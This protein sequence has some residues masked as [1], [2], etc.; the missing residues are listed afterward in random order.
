MR[1]FIDRL[2]PASW[3]R[4]MRKILTFFKTQNPRREGQGHAGGWLEA[5][6]FTRRHAK[7]PLD[8]SAVTSFVQA[9][10]LSILRALCTTLALGA[11]V[12]VALSAPTN[13]IAGCMALLGVGSANC[14]AAPSGG[15]YV[16]PANV[17]G[18][19]SPYGCWS[20][21]ACT[22]AYA[23]AG[24]NIVDLVDQS[25]NNAIT[26]TA[27]ANGNI[28]LAAINAWVT[29]NSVTGI[30]VT[31]WYDQSGNGQHLVTPTAF[32][33]KPQ[34]LLSGASFG[35]IPVISFPATGADAFLVSAS[36]AVALAQ[37]LTTSS[38]MFYPTFSSTG[39]PFT[40]GTFSFQPIAV[41]TSNNI[42]QQFTGS[43]IDYPVT[44][45]AWQSLQSVADGAASSMSVNGSITVASTTPGT[46]GI[47]STAQLN[48]G[49]G[50]LA[51][52]AGNMFE[53]IVIPAHV[54]TANQA[55]QTSNQRAYGGF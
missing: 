45:N 27:L 44:S 37:P 20:L 29:A 48:L 7:D 13:A 32:N 35:S 34:L 25:G 24:G 30:Q 49:G 52:F 10:F 28:N 18:Y 3:S 11:V 22:A 39:E 23:A 42:S 36:N 1:D 41:V 33:T 5:R 6:G 47:G 8:A 15:G 9:R 51:N 26:I 46:S 2:R 54:S 12:F 19:T 50:G 40:D 38:V 43:R 14:G 21:R 4:Y 16:G 31:T 55:L 53:L 17:A